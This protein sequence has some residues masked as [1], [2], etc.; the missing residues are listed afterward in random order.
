ME[1]EELAEVAHEARRHKERRIGMTMAV[2]A[3][4][5][6]VTTMLG[7]RAHTEEVVLQTQT[8]DDW[9]FYQAKNGR[10][11][12]YEADAELA[13]LSG[14]DGVRLA[15]TFRG[16]AAKEK[17]DAAGIHRTAELREDETRT[18]ARR[19]SFFDASEIFLEVAI[20]LCSIALLADALVFWRM[21]FISAAIGIA[22]GACGLLGVTLPI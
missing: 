8:T 2:F 4:L 9:A 17:S 18:A 7:H 15:A 19:A 13:Q 3:A 5:L 22:I 10:G 1:A 20:V 11:Q 6:A 12:M 16:R 14:A 21:S